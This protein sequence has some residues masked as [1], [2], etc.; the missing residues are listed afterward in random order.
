[1]YSYSGGIRRRARVRFIC[2]RVFREVDLPRIKYTICFNTLIVFLFR[3]VIWL[4]ALCED[5]EL[6]V[7]L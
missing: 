1:M 4:H 2:T 3:V 5:G 6:K 7:Y